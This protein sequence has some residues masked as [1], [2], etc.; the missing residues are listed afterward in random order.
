MTG[1]G[2]APTE[3]TPYFINSWAAR[4]GQRVLARLVD[5][6]IALGVVA[7]VVVGG[8]HGRPLA[9]DLLI[10][11]FLAAF[12][13]AMLT[14][15]GA[16]MGMSTVGIR[17]APLDRSGHPDWLQATRRTIPV[18]ACYAVLP[19][20]VVLAVV[21]AVTL[22]VSIAWS[23]EGRAFHDR[24]S[25]TV[26]VQ[27]SAPNPIRT[28][29]LERW[30]HPGRQPVLS[31]WG[32]VPGV[33]ERRRARAHRLEGTALAAGMIAVA[34]IVLVGL[35]GTWWVWAGLTAVWV[36]ISIVDETRQVADGGTNPGHR[37]F[38]YRVVDLATGATPSA[39]RA[40]LRALV[41][42]PMLCVPPLQLVLVLWVQGSATNRGPHDLLAR[43]V[44]IDPAFEP[45]RFHPRPFGFP[46]GAPP[47]PPPYRP[48][49]PPRP[50][51]GP[52]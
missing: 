19:P 48:P 52:F 40:F 16:T 43:T 36:V 45:P 50:I 26:V 23:P 2:V 28:A 12:E 24:A 25:G 30:W 18:V 9:Q 10:I 8:P 46:W 34:G 41:L 11:G 39:N 4:T 22:V 5:S 32:R 37:R 44:L 7:A 17:V 31:P 49:P 27:L 6:A 13:V 38:G 47:P 15:S 21:L 51:P 3:T 42:V 35:G 33:F 1:H 20:G 14:R 29:D